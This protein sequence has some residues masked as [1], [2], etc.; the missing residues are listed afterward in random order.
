MKCH[1]MNLTKVLVL[2]I[3]L[4]SNCQTT[5]QKSLQEP[6]RKKMIFIMRDDHKIVGLVKKPE[7][8]GPF[9]VVIYLH[10][11]GGMGYFYNK[12]IKH[13][14]L[15]GFVGVAY[16]RRGFPF[17]GGQG[18]KRIRYRDYIF[19]DVSDLSTVIDQLRELSFI[20]SAPIGTIGWSEGAHVAYL[21]ASQI[22]D[23]KA[24]VGLGGAYDYLESYYWA[25]AHY[26]KYPIEKLRNYTKAVKKI[27]GCSP[28]QCRDRY[29]ALSPIHQVEKVSCPIM[30][31]K[32]E[33]D[34][35]GP[36]SSAIRY[37]DALRVAGKPREIYVYSNEGHFPAFFS[38]PNFGTNTAANWLES[39]VW[40]KKNSL[41]ALAKIDIFLSKN[42]K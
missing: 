37:A 8:V 20:G 22:N 21:A 11:V 40:T 24:V 26:S 10:G 23:L 15:N 29:I 42:L 30:I 18:D 39:Q 4:C 41:D 14:T 3:L 35:F 33:K 16:A 6:M 27:F 25:E 32:G 36:V 38:Y 19:K 13:L 31:I 1:R 9:P 7:G 2:V 5:G 34:A 28:E 17:G 12:L